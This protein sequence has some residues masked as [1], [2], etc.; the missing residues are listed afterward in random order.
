MSGVSAIG[1]DIGGTHVR[2]ARISAIGEV[3]DWTARPTATEPSRVIPQIAELVQSLDEASV[4][5]IGIAVPGRVDSRRGKVL[6]GGYV[7][8][9]GQPLA[10]TIS[11]LTRRPVFLDND[12]NAAL[13]A[14]HATGA[15]RTA[16]T[17]VMFT[18]GTGIGGAVMIHGKMLRGRAS[19]GQLGH[20]AVDGS[21]RACLCGRH[22]CVETTSS[23]TALGRHVAEAGLVAGTSV[24][25]LLAHAS[26][27]DAVAKGVLDAWAAPMR[28]AMD[29]VVAIF[30]PD[31][32]VLG[33]G[34][35]SAMHQ[36]LT[37]F[38]A[39]A[40]WYTCPVVPASLGD[41]AGVIGAGLSAHMRRS[42]LARAAS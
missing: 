9:S 25:T 4:A 23:G 8:L 37:R 10:E 30:D 2:A 16:S 39:K 19:A 41:R 36:A 32:I 21:G 22:G 31:L 15:A 1:V 5:A 42:D 24:Q 35:G 33:G 18:I 13:I 29:T 12:G 40:A 34:L 26:E 28:I 3:L 11:G 38:P 27:G 20:I 17:V 6:S 7:D 14:E